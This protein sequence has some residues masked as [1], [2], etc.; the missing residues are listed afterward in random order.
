MSPVLAR[1]FDVR[2]WDMLGWKRAVA[3]LVAADSGTTIRLVHR[4]GANQ[5]IGYRLFYMLQF[6]KQAGLRVQLVTDGLFWI[7]EADEWLIECEVDEIVLLAADGCLS[8]ALAER[9]RALASRGHHAIKV[10]PAGTCDLIASRPRSP[11]Q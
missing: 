9:M 6:A 8:D 7:E 11:R 2:E 10:E 1:T 4:G 5:I 3:E